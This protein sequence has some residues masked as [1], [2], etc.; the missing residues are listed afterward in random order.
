MKKVIIIS[1]IFPYPVDNGKKVVLNGLL[2]YFKASKDHYDIKYVV[3]DNDL[4]IND[5]NVDKENLEIV[6]FNQPKSIRKIFNAI[7]YSLIKREKSI[8]ES[9]IF[10]P[11]IMNELNLFLENNQADM[12]IVDTIRIGQFLEKNRPFGHKYILY[13]DDLFSVRYNKML[14]AY[15]SYPGISLNSLGNFKKFIPNYLHFMVR[16][17]FIEKCLLKFESCLIEKREKQIVKSFEH[18]LLINKDEVKRLRMKTNQENIYEIK[19]LLPVISEE[20]REY[21]QNKQFIFLGALNIPHNNFS[22][23]NF[24]KTQMDKIIQLIPDC[25][26]LVIGKNPSEELMILAEKYKDNLK[27]E[28]YIEDI[29]KVFSESCAMLV[30]LLFGSGV[31]LKTLEAISRGLPV[32]GTDYAFEG[33]DMIHPIHGILENNIDNYPEIMKKLID[34]RYNENLSKQAKNF[35]ENQYSKEAIFKHYQDLF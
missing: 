16:S 23:I 8:Q 9:M 2:E 35:F 21:R 29:N 13:L 1:S 20:T 34:N 31:K 27:I 10:S 15:K 30:P 24:I 3:V 11:K 25:E 18:N 28:G 32:I 19:P 7:W 4:N 6:Q 26:I 17:S 14:E 22:I 12:V 5:L 33:I